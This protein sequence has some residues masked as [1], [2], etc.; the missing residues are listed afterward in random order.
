MPIE[1]CVKQ[2]HEPLPGLSGGLRYIVA[3]GGTFLERRTALYHTCVHVEPTLPMLDGH[4]EFC[5]LA[6][7]PLPR[8]LVRVM[9]G[10][11]RRAYEV[12]GGE[13]ALVLLYDPVGR[14]Y[15]WLC[16]PQTVTMHWSW[17]RY[18]ASEWIQFA[19]PVEL[20]PGYIQLGDAHSHLGPPTPSGMDRDDERYQDG[21]HLIIGDIAK[22]APTWH[23]DFCI[24]GKR[25][26]IAPPQIIAQLPPPPHLGPPRTW[27]ERIVLQ[28]APRYNA[29][30]RSVDNSRRG[31]R[32]WYE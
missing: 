28:Y 27:M 6:C 8:T 15:R 14:R 13:A 4:E 3:R 19:A 10:F 22:A 20:P 1:V 7:P 17:D 31:K 30:P 21:L 25:F 2:P 23:I 32:R 12:H 11:F 24:D 18:R 26:T 5:R 29:A 16:P 9:L